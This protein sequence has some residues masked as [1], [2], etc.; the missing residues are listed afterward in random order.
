MS[1]FEKM[2][3]AWRS[4]YLEAGAKTGAGLP[5][6]KGQVAAQIAQNFAAYGQAKPGRSREVVMGEAG[7]FLKYMS[8]LACR[9]AGPVVMNIHMQHVVDPFGADGDFWC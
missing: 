7:E 8:F 9:N 2:K 1:I 4:G 6:I 5:W 3:A